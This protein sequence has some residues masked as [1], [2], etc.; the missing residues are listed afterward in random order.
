MLQKIQ[1]N[2]IYYYDIKEKQDL[3]QFR[4]LKIFGKTELILEECGPDI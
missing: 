3:K 4:Y 2:M 1:E